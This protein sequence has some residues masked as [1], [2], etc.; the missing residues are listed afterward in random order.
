[1]ILLSLALVFTFAKYASSGGKTARSVR[2]GARRIMASGASSGSSGVDGARGTMRGTGRG[3]CS[4]SSCRGSV[5]GVAGD[6]GGTGASAGTSRGR[7]RFCT[8][9]GRMSTISS[10]LSGLSSRFRCT[11]RVGRV[12]FRACGT[13]RHA[14]RG[15]RSRLRLTRRTLRG[16]C[17]VS[18]WFRV[19]FFEGQRGRVCL[20]CRIHIRVPDSYGGSRPTCSF[21]HYQ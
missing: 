8:L 1:M 13:E 11:C 20:L 10:R 16:G 21:N 6:M 7:R 18:S 12:D 15:L 4:F 2:V 3:S 9:G 14:V 19:S 17:S 5:H